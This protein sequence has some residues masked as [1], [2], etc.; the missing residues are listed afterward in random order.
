M[1]PTPPRIEPLDLSRLKV[2]PLERRETLT[3]V[4]E[5]LVDPDSPPPAVPPAIAATISECMIG[6]TLGLAGRRKASR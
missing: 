4:G 5:I 3:R 1:S 2:L 6:S